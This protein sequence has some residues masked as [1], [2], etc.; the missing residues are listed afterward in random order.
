[1]KDVLLDTNFLTLPHI[2]GLDVFTELARILPESH[3]CVVLS[4]TVAELEGLCSGASNASIAARVGLRL[5]EEKDVRVVKSKGSVDDA[6]VDYA[7]SHGD[8]VVA[9]ND[10][11]LKKRLRE[12]KV[13][14]ISLRGESNLT[15][16]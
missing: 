4:G 12:K 2:H 14:V 5:I 7:S 9:T 1:M 10:R 11:E 3:S 13:S 6:I 8:V 15:I 16:N